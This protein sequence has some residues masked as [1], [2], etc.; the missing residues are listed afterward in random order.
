MPPGTRRLI[1][2]TT[3]AIV[4]L[5]IIL[6]VARNLHHLNYSVGDQAIIQLQAED[7]PAHVPLVGVYSRLGFHHPGPFLYAVAAPTVRWL[8]GVGLVVIAAA[9]AISCLVGLLLVLYRRGGPVLFALGAVFSVVL[10]RSM[11]LDVLSM[12]NPYVLILPF[13]LAIALTWSVWCRDWRMLPWLALVGSFVAQ[14]H[15]GLV[16]AIAFLFG[17]AAVF[18]VM[19]WFRSRQVGSRSTDHAACPRRPLL[20]SIAVLAVVWAPPLFDQLTGDPGNLTRI[21]DAGSSVANGQRLGVAHGLGLLGLL[22]GRVDP[23]RFNSTDDL[24]ILASVH[25]GSILW[26]MIP[27]VVL[28]VSA[29][30]A[31]RYQLRDQL[32]LSA[33]LFGLVLVSVL[34]MALIIGLPYLYLERW[35]VVISAFIWLNL[36]WTALSAVQSR[37]ERRRLTGGQFGEGRIRLSTVFGTIGVPLMFLVA[38]MPLAE[39]PGHAN[40]VVG[41]AA[42]AAVIGPTR[43]AIADCVLV[44]VA[45]EGSAASLLVAS[46]LV[47]Q[48]H[49]DGFNVAID[50]LFAFSHGEQHSL[51][52]RT[53]SCALIV[54]A[55][56]EPVPAAVSDP[57]TISVADSLTPEQRT[58]FQR[59]SLLDGAGDG[60][61]VLDAKKATALVE[62]RNS[63]M[64]WCVQLRKRAVATDN[65]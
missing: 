23:L 21:L 4:A 42:I 41:S 34:A 60:R 28:A 48:L 15:L 52:G 10:T 43:A 27:F 17:S 25:D 58:Q 49:H 24:R 44:G 7:I 45:P 29:G 56:A 6:S 46:G 38:L 61:P 62:L 20:L 47:A 55:S 53:A 9:L 12:W 2:G 63:A 14:A 3:L 26:L 51:R 8:G 39:T 13:A 22:L 37:L 36:V 59:L 33:L 5:P 40:D 64:V 1:C 16:P 30:I 54:A 57:A 19:A 35:L 65:G 31:R 50:D 18:V 11:A 32:R